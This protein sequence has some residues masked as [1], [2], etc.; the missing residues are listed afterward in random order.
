MKNDRLFQI[1]Y[2]LLEK[3]SITAPK[4]AELLEVSVRTVYRDIY[5]L[6]CAGIP[7]YTSPGKGGGITLSEHYA[8]DKLILSEEEQNQILYALQS[9]QAANAEN[10]DKLIAKLG[11]Q[12]HKGYTN[13]IEVDFSRWGHNKI[14]K[15]KFELLKKS[16]IDKMMIEIVYCN[17]SGTTDIRT[18][19]PFKMIFKHRGWYV[20][21]YCCRACDFRLFKVNR[22]IDIH[23]LNIGFNDDFSHMSPVEAAAEYPSD[24]LFRVILKFPQKVAY[25]V[26]DEFNFTD[27]TRQP[28]GSF[29]VEMELPDDS[30]LYGYLL[31]FGVDVDILEPQSVKER[32]ADIAQKI[33]LKNKI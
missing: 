12:F 28:D 18:V 21:A 33:F 7:I 6:S 32:I 26:L 27:I 24:H 4:L 11:T 25:R 30:W 8:F 17:S 2:I 29:I 31:T 1:V 13:W 22:I 10:T 14:D 16:I 20:L 23:W 5:A 15:D 3:R 19:K 9:I